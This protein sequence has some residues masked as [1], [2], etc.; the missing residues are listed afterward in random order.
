MLKMNILVRK[1]YINYKRILM[2][3]EILKNTSMIIKQKWI[4]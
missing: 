1:M 3:E 2:D 4:I